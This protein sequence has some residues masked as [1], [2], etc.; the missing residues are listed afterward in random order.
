M[1]QW[2]TWCESLFVDES[3]WVLDLTPHGR[4]AEYGAMVSGLRTFHRAVDYNSNLAAECSL[5]V[6]EHALCKGNMAWELGADKRIIS[7]CLQPHMP[8]YWGMHVRHFENVHVYICHKES[9]A[10]PILPRDLV[11]KCVR[12][13]DEWVWVEKVSG[14]IVIR[15]KPVH[16]AV[17]PG[18][19]ICNSEPVSP[20]QPAA[21]QQPV[22]ALA[23]PPPAA[24]QQVA[25]V[26][27]PRPV[28]HAD[29]GDMD[30][31]SPTDKTK[32]KKH[33]SEKAARS[34]TAT[35]AT[36]G[37]EGKDI[38]AFTV[39]TDG[40]EYSFKELC[41]NKYSKK[42]EKKPRYREATGAYIEKNSK[43]HWDVLRDPKR[44]KTK[45]P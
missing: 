26:A 35:R 21:L 19:T 4:F 36:N 9:I 23:A 10:C 30:R 32:L 18:V 25:V 38:D 45:H 2:F 27:A 29:R 31:L 40:K 5:I 44:Y 1:E 20:G 28:P 6:C 43:D 34:A 16:L 33:L 3:D 22:L 12:E 14:V 39:H 41:R 17:P 7:T 37:L 13:G 42:G 24:A 8:D 11:G 15:R